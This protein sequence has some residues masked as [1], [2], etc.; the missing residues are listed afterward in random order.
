MFARGNRI[1]RSTASTAPAGNAPASRSANGWFSKAAAARRFR[2][3]AMELPVEFHPFAHVFL[4]LEGLAKCLC[5]LDGLWRHHMRHRHAQRVGLEDRAHLEYLD[6]LG[7]RQVGDDRSAVARKVTKPSDSSRLSASRTAI[8]LT[9]NSRATSS[10]RVGSPSFKYP[11]AIAARMWRRI[12]SMA[13]KGDPGV[14]SETWVDL[15]PEISRGASRRQDRLRLEGIAGRRRAGLVDSQI[16]GRCQS[17][18]Q[19]GRGC[20]VLAGP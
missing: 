4:V 20:P 10:W 9:L 6:K 12:I 15:L 18:H 14:S 5:R 17:R 7:I 16:R 1:G 13:E 3:G 11:S 2:R 19:D 8:L